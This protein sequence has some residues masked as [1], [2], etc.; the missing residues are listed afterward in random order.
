MD[1]RLTKYL[2]SICQSLPQPVIF[3]NIHDL[4]VHVAN[5]FSYTPYECGVCIN[6]NQPYKFSTE[7]SLLQ[8]YSQC[9]PE[10]KRY[11]V[12]Q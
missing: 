6:L 11:Y 2:C 7:N 12:N 4:E 1:L 10:T 5:H 8:H 9:H 3:S